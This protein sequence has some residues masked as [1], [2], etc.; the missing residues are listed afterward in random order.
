MAVVDEWKA[1]P[2]R[3]GSEVINKQ[4]T[5]KLSYFRDDY[6]KMNTIVKGPSDI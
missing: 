5:I 3:F 6:L 1:T 4:Q 2:A